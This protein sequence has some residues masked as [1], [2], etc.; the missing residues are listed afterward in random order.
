[1]SHEIRTPMNA[2]VGM[3]SIAK[4]MLDDKERTL[5]CLEKIDASTKSLIDIVNEMLHIKQKN[6]VELEGQRKNDQKNG[7]GNTPN[8]SFQGK[9]I[10]LVEDN[11]LNIEVARTLLEMVGFEV[12]VA[13]NG[14]KAVEK[15]EKNDEG[16]YNAVL[17]DIRMPI[18]DGLEATRQIRISGKN[19]SRTIPIIALTAN[20]FDEDTQKSIANG[21]NGHLVKPL[22]V[23]NLYQVLQELV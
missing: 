17:M 13:D 2:I 19:D 16:W 22:D 8:Y 3:A 11:A 7:I 20:A 10:L 5:D 1:M 18:M 14:L 12:D 23:Q 4:N 15:F 9:R 21:M 6:Y